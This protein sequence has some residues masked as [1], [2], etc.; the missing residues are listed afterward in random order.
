MTALTFP[1]LRQLLEGSGFEVTVLLDT[2]GPAS[3]AFDYE[4]ARDGVVLGVR[5][6]TDW[7]ASPPVR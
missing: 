7:S 5:I 4:V 3:F 1:Q 2:Y 6:A